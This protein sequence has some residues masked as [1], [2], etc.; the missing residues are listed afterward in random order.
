MTK[1][2]AYKKGVEG[3]EYAYHAKP[4]VKKDRAAR[5]KARREAMADGKVAKSD[6]KHLDHKVPLSKGGSRDTSNTRVVSATENREKY[7]NTKKK[8]KG[9]KS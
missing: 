6:G 3:S 4:E 5:N 2:R 9:K 1:K 8:P 7:N